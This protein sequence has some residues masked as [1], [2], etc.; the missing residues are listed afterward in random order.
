MSDPKRSKSRSGISTVVGGALIIGIILSVIAPLFIYMNNMTKFYDATAIEMRDVDQQ[1]RWESLEVYIR[2]ESLTEHNISVVVKNYSPQSI[3]ITRIWVVL[4]ETYDYNY[5]VSNQNMI[6]DPQERVIINDANVISFTEPCDYGSYEIKVGTERGNYFN[7]YF[8]PPEPPYPGYSLPL[9]IK[10]N[11]SIVWQGGGGGGGGSSTYFMDLTIE[12]WM[13]EKLNVTYIVFTT[14]YPG[15]GGGTPSQS[16]VLTP[17]LYPSIL[18]IMF[19]QPAEP[20]W[21]WSTTTPFLI[22]NM[23][24]GAEYAR[25]ELVSGDNI[26]IGSHYFKLP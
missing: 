3:Y 16:K 1:R 6:L 14:L 19:P 17:S 10:G 24:P 2:N 26:V 18:P 11:Q 22:E 7:A 20:I 4:N 5:Y 25:V 9:A 23:G 21:E 8:P 15:G 12:N 13:E